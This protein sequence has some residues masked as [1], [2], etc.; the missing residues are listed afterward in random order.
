MELDW[1]R[2]VATPVFGCL[3]A[4][5]LVTGE[6]KIVARALL[7]LAW[8]F[9]FIWFGED[10]AAATGLH[11]GLVNRPSRASLIRIGGWVI[12]AIYLFPILFS[13]IAA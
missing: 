6:P 7:T 11:F 8:P 9:V 5:A 12:L 3:F 10:L 4:A 13:V 1:H 2:A